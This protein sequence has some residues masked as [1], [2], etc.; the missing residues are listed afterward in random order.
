MHTT[1]RLLLAFLAVL[2]L[3]AQPGAVLI[4]MAR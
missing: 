3:P 4:F 1:T 2:A